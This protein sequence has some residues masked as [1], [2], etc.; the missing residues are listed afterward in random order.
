LISPYTA[1]A[2]TFTSEAITLGTMRWYGAV[3]FA[4]IPTLFMVF[5]QA[6]EIYSAMRFGPI[7]WHLK[8]IE[9]FL[10]CAPLCLL[11]A[12]T[13]YAVATRCVGRA[14][15]SALL[16]G[17][18]VGAGWALVVIIGG[19]TIAQSNGAMPLTLERLIRMLIVIPSIFIPLGV[20]LCIF[21]RWRGMR[22]GLVSPA[23]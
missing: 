9:P 7:Y 18:A 16:L 17:C 20:V 4:F 6:S 3:Y 21:T 13:G 10:F 1:P 12:G 11:M 22:L 14:L 15:G 19:N 2:S 5:M 23:K 8:I